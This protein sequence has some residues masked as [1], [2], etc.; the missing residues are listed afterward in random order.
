MF[1]NFLQFLNEKTDH[2]V[3]IKASFRLNVIERSLHKYLF[4]K[5]DL[6]DDGC[7]IKKADKFCLCLFL[8][9]KS[10]IYPFFIES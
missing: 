2:L 1:E 3:L 4:Y 7:K 10:T 6:F 8:S 5:Q 9:V